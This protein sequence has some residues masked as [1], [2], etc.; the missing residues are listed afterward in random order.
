MGFPGNS[1]LTSIFVITYM[2][3][4]VT[5]LV[6][7]SPFQRDGAEWHA[8]PETAVLWVLGFKGI[9][10]KPVLEVGVTHCP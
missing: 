4:S 8:M 3:I 6:I 1:L 5:K 7:S 9:A 2:G 10:S